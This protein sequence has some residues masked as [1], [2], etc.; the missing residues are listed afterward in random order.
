MSALATSELPRGDAGGAQAPPE[1]GWLRR[2]FMR[3]PWHFGAVIGVLFLT[4]Y[5]AAGC[6][7]FEP[8]APAVTGQLEGFSLSAAAGATVTSEDLAGEVW[9]ASFTY[10]RCPEARCGAP[11]ERLEALAARWADAKVPVRIVTFTVDPVHDTPERLSAWTTA[12]GITW[13]VLTA[14]TDAGMRAV[15]VGGFRAT[16]GDPT[17]EADGSLDIPH[18]RRVAIVDGGGRVRGFYENSERG[19]DEVFWRAQHVLDEMREEAKP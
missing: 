12:R 6:G 5:R 7:V 10:T 14:A 15:V 8:R 9:L 2:T 13:P 3:Y 17:A 11:I 1:H 4:L 19:L 18:S 16:M